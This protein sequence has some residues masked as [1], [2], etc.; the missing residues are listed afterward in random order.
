MNEIVAIISAISSVVSTV[1]AVLTYL[2]GKQNSRV[3]LSRITDSSKKDANF[4]GQ[5]TRKL[6]DIGLT[7]TKASQ[8]NHQLPTIVEY[9]N[10]YN[11]RVSIYENSLFVLMVGFGILGW[12]LTN[13]FLIG[14][15]TFFII[16]LIVGSTVWEV[17]VKNGSEELKKLVRSQMGDPQVE[18]SLRETLTSI[19]WNWRT[20]DYVTPIIRELQK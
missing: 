3:N 7:R 20:R 9:A 13:N 14:V 19:K 8:I 16:G 17:V 6:D 18:L 12:S 4:A 15:V 1:I 2:D 11:K 10:Q 5:S